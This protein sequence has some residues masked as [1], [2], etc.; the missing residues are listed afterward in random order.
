MKPD[1]GSARKRGQWAEELAADTLKD[2]GLQPLTNNYRCRWG[3]I[4]LIMRDAQTVVFVEVRFRSRTDFGD[5]AESIDARKRRRLV[6]AAQHF[7]QHNPALGDSA[8]R[9]DVVSVTGGTSGDKLEWIKS[10]FEA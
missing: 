5:G 1:A 6:A 9:F 7:L 3:E 10:A 4:D 2:R 8:C